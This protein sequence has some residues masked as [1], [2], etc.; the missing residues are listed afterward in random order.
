MSAPSQNG[1]NHGE[2]GY[3][4]HSCL[5][6]RGFEWLPTAKYVVRDTWSLHPVYIPFALL[7]DSTVALR[8]LSLTFS[9]C[10]FGGP[11]VRLKLLVVEKETAM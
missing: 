8:E 3:S 7:N 9:S 4:L 10:A 1:G 5:A 6:T 2:V 11:S